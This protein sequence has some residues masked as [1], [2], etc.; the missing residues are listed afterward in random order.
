MNDFRPLAGLRVLELAGFVSGPFCGKLLA[1]LGAEVAKIEPPGG[2]PARRY[3]PFRDDVPDPARSGIFMYLN[4]A[5]RLAERGE[6]ASL[7]GDCDVVIVDGAADVPDLEARPG[8]VVIAVTPFGLTGPKAGW[9]GGDLIAAA[10]S[11]F[12]SLTGWPDREPLRPGGLVILHQ[13]G[14]H[15]AIATLLQLGTGR[16]GLVDVSVQ[17]AGAWP[18]VVAPEFAFDGTVARPKGPRLQGAHGV[19]LQRTRDGQ[20]LMTG[21]LPERSMWESLA[22]FLGHPAWMAD[23]RFQSTVSRS[24]HADEVERLAAPEL[25]R[26]TRTEA[27]EE[28]QA[29]R[30][31][32]APVQTFAEIAESPQLAIRGFWTAAE[33]LRMPGAPA[34]VSR[35]AGARSSAPVPPGRTKGDRPLA[36]ITV[37]DFSRVWAGPVVTRA[38]AENGARVIKIE[39]RARPDTSRFLRPLAG[40]PPDGSGWFQS[41]NFGK[42]DVTLDLKHPEGA[43]LARAL[44]ARADV[45][46]E[47]FSPGVMDRLGLG[48]TD[49]SEGRPDLVM[50]SLSGL[51]QTG[52]QRHWVM[53]GELVDALSGMM[54]ITGYP[55]GGPMIASAACGDP[56]S[57]LMGALHVLA[58]LRERERT[59]RGAYIDLSMHQTMVGLLGEPAME[60]AL[61]GRAMGRRGN[62][63]PRATVHGVF[64]CL[65]AD[66]WIAIA[67]DAEGA[68]R[69]RDLAGDADLTAWTRTQDDGAL[70]ERLQALGVAAAGVATVADLFVDPQ[71]RT[72]G[73]V[74]S[75]DH[76]VTGPHD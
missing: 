68:R 13:A 6:L 57:G 60:W 11:G 71:L 48:W 53:F 40:G 12:M 75:V 76:P 10:A 22:K 74:R 54:H 31:P 67:A 41:W 45:V 44:A 24:E 8:I 50:L 26:F 21:F 72:R 5:K 34:I 15:A 18:Q 62:A 70:A 73:F 52:P 65:G 28:L 27:V 29:L 30:V 17:E 20:W 49:L 59:G 51:G 23:P 61:N 56:V 64:P 47:N 42:L 4:H 58:A 9:L 1:D 3:G 63:D 7:L 36:G 25:A 37:L 35:P 43:A 55:D 19:G 38:L 69:L 66:R 2:D 39:G 16:G 33:G 32:V 14:L 46:V